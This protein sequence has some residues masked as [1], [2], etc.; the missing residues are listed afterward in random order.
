MKK[1][2]T[3]PQKISSFSPLEVLLHQ[4]KKQAWS[5]CTQIEG[6]VL[7]A[8]EQIDWNYFVLILET[9]WI[10]FSSP[11]HPFT[12]SRPVIDA[13]GS[14]A[15][16]FCL[17]L[18]RSMACGLLCWGQHCSHLCPCLLCLPRAVLSKPAAAQYEAPKT[19]LC[20]LC[21]QHIWEFW[22]L[23]EEAGGKIQEGDLPSF[24]ISALLCEQQYPVLLS[25]S[26]VVAQ[27]G[28]AKALAH[29]EP[30]SHFS[31]RGTSS[32]SVQK[33]NSKQMTS[34]HNSIIFYK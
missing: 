18:C 9:K 6:R 25:I 1:V 3:S 10:L 20:A 4:E 11:D 13:P 16:I 29:I 7:S 5:Q 8:C 34:N 23:K 12:R 17:T 27:C 21:T 19:V 24:S 2:V 26:K 28:L 15:C 30:L 31:S 33:V 14:R 22:Q 32:P